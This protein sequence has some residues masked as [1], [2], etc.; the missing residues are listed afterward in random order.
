MK[1][2]IFP[3]CLLFFYAI[4]SG[5]SQNADLAI[6]ESALN[7]FGLNASFAKLHDNN[8][9]HNSQQEKIQTPIS[10]HNMRVVTFVD[11]DGQEYELPTVENN[12]NCGGILFNYASFDQLPVTPVIEYANYSEQGVVYSQPNTQY[13]QYSQQSGYTQQAS[14]TTYTQTSSQPTEHYV[15]NTPQPTVEYT[16]TTKINEYNEPV[17][18]YS[19]QTT[20]Y[21]QPVTYSEDRSVFQN[22][23]ASNQ[24]TTYTNVPATITNNNNQNTTV[25][26]AGSVFNNE[27][28]AAV[29]AQRAKGCNCGGEYMAPVPAI[30]WDMNLER[31]ANRHVRD[32]DQHNNFSH[33]GT[34]NSSPDDR[35]KAAGYNR[36]ENFGEN[37]GMGYISIS[38]AMEGWL[39]SPGHCK[40]IMS[41]DTLYIGASRSGKMWCQAFGKR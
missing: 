41:P 35:A 16:T 18:T 17:I 20:E 8:V 11:V 32:M 4:Q 25:A 27:M 15:E 19:T 7:S 33:F 26:D 5:L 22:Q 10:T 9:E 3:I 6:A 36:S 12:G 2:T 28:L 30:Q 14:E 38:H 21:Q 23:G 40:G 24:Q 29:N 1:N 31:A 13:G 39:N 37:I 34:D